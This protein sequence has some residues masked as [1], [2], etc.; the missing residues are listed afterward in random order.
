[1]VTNVNMG[2]EKLD[3]SSETWPPIPQMLH[4]HDAK[5]AFDT[6]VDKSDACYFTLRGTTPFGA[7]CFTNLYFHKSCVYGKSPILDPFID[8]Q[9]G[10]LFEDVHLKDLNEL[11]FRRMLGFFYDYDMNYIE[12]KYELAALYK[13]AILFMVKS[14]E[15]FC[16]T[17]LLR[18]TTSLQSSS[19]QVNQEDE[20]IDKEISNVI[21]PKNFCGEIEK[22][23]SNHVETQE[24]PN[25]EKP[26]SLKEKTI[27]ISNLKDD[28]ISEMVTTLKFEI[29]QELA[30]SVKDDLKKLIS[31]DLLP[32]IEQRFRADAD[33]KDHITQGII[34][35][36]REEL[37]NEMRN[38]TFS[39]VRLQAILQTE[40]Y[41][42]DDFQHKLCVELRKQLVS[43]M[44]DEILPEMGKNI[45]ARILTDERTKTQLLGLMRSKF[46]V[47]E[48]FQEELMQHLKVSIR[49]EFS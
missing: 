3:D 23:I 20:E 17:K 19:D 35:V 7:D 31:D 2:A 9:N 39:K 37:N 47:N 40:L 21:S 14:V 22:Q 8:A 6:T 42:D 28:I 36:V 44:K 41:D 33:F 16:L 49:K 18:P 1:M 24:S 15:D 48:D 11:H 45:K 5:L 12:D 26:A 32:N 30:A 43:D 25:C 38:D 10:N 46:L 34:A 29:Q 27:V 4:P 13:M